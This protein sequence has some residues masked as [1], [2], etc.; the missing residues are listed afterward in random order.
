MPL[1]GEGAVHPEQF[2]SPSQGLTFPHFDFSYADMTNA[3][4]ISV[5]VFRVCLF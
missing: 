4:F 3:C 2:T 1:Q 5:L